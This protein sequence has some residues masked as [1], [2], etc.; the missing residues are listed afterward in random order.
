MNLN[1]HILFLLY[2]N[3]FFIQGDFIQSIIILSHVLIISTII[4]III[5]V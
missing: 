3:I 2:R 1:D 5:D 4:D